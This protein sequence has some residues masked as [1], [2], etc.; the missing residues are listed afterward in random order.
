MLQKTVREAAGRR[1]HVEAYASLHAPAGKRRER[2]LQLLAAAG[3][4]A[5]LRLDRHGIIRRNLLRRLRR[6]LPVHAHLALH[7]E[8]LR[9]R[10]RRHEPAFDKRAV[11]AALHHSS[12]LMFRTSALRKSWVIPSLTSRRYVSG[13]SLSISTP[14]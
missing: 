1:P 7:H 6:N 3:H 4:E 5:R 14:R 9:N 8:G 13:L 2:P 11:E 10:S 12:V